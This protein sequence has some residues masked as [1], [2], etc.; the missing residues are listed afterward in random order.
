MYQYAT[1]V[2]DRIAL[3]PEWLEGLKRAKLKRI[4]YSCGGAT[5]AENIGEKV[6]IMAEL[7]DAGGVRNRPHQTR[8]AVLYE[9]DRSMRG[10]RA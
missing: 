3:E 10:V 7:Q 1:S 8:R 2:P 5:N 6:R 9:R 4:E